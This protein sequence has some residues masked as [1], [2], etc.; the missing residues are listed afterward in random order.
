[1]EERMKITHDTKIDIFELVV[2]EAD[3]R[4]AKEYELFW[5]GDARLLGIAL[6]SDDEKLLFHR[7][8]LEV[9]LNS[10]EVIPENYDAKM[11]M[12]GLNI[13]P[14]ER[15]MPTEGFSVGNAKLEI[16][17]RDERHPETQFNPYMV[18]IYAWLQR[19]CPKG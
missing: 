4:V 15:F 14:S 8:T 16:K 9:L 2:G 6:T 11:L 13:P 19:A 10:K 1:M 12:C 18:K 17:Y 5:D 7:G 3:A